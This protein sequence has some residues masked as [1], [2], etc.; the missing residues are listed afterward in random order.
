MQGAVDETSEDLRTTFFDC[1]RKNGLNMEEHCLQTKDQTIHFM[2]LSAPWAVLC[3]YAEEMSM[4]VPLKACFDK[5]RARRHDKIMESG[6][7]YESLPRRPP[8]TFN[9]N[10]KVRKLK[11]FLGSENQDTFFTNTQRHQILYEILANALYG[12]RHQGE[13]GV[14]RLLNE[15]VFVA[16]YPL[17]DEE[18]TNAPETPEDRLTHRQ[19]LA[20]YW[21]P[22]LKWYKYQPLNHIRK[23]FGE[24]I[25]FYFAWLGFY[26]TWLLPAAVIGTLIFVFGFYVASR[27]IPVMEVCQSGDLYSMCP[28][29]KVCPTWNLSSI[30]AI[31]KAGILFDNAGT[32]L[33]SFFMS[34]WS[35]TFLEYWKRYNATLSYR[36]DCLDFTE[37]EEPAR[38]EFTAMAPLTIQNPITGQNEP[39]FPKTWRLQRIFAGSMV[40]M[41]MIAVVIIFLI[42]VILYRIIIFLLVVKSGMIY[43]SASLIASITG[44]MISLIITLML[45]K[46]YVSLARFLTRWELHR[47]QTA[48]EDAFTF[49]VFIFEFVNYYATPIYIAFIKGRFLGYP[50]NEIT[51]AGY[52]NENCKPGGCLIELAQQML[53]IMVG[54][55]ILNNIKEILFPKLEHFWHN[56]TLRSNEDQGHDQNKPWERDYRLIPYKGLFDEYLEMVIQFGFITIFVAACPLAPL[57]ALL[58]NWI[59]VRLDAK[60][61]VYEYRRPVAQRAQDIGVWTAIL[62]AITSIAVIGNAFLVAFTS[63]ILPRAYYQY[64]NNGNLTGYINFSLAQ[65]PEVYVRKNTPCRYQGMRDSEGNLSFDFW[66]I[67]VMRLAFIILFEHVVF[68]LGRMIDFLVPDVPESVDIKLRRERFLAKQALA[69]N[70]FLT[71][72]WQMSPQMVNK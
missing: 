53:I 51:I 6:L 58:N 66:V 42:S 57:F 54:K 61:F 5:L 8:E 69:E 40:I 19:I 23:Y 16:A 18:S 35:V 62:E 70:E 31:Y 1:L 49:K 3:Y 48:Y 38:P 52:R 72:T 10:F 30:C 7:L 27:D 47:T 32:L 25:A 67:M 22:W 9:C 21:A 45:S 50:G 43:S 2:L 64:Y 41:L 37:I 71:E 36:W 46:V 34:V 63:D 56:F 4:K 12:S 68:F 44:S 13:V 55:Q 29:C 15:N 26:T 39:Y 59:E 65:A 17:H 33:F 24:K 11:S 20:K 28:V 60:K 14:E